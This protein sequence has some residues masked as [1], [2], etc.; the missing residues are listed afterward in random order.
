MPPSHVPSLGLKGRCLAATLSD[1]KCGFYVIIFFWKDRP[2]SEGSRNTDHGIKSP[3][4]TLVTAL[5]SA[6]ALTMIMSDAN[7][8]QRCARAA[9][10]ASNPARFEAGEK[11]VFSLPFHPLLHR[12]LSF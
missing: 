10:E 6:I 5:R 9:K 8:S 7:A 3:P 12:A 2:Q 1:F 4:A 11:P